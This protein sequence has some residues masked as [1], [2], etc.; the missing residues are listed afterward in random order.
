MGTWFQSLVEQIMMLETFTKYLHDHPTV[1]MFSA[2]AGYLAT[3]F[4]GQD[5]LITTLKFITIILGT[6]I[7]AITLYLKL[8]S[9]VEFRREKKKQKQLQ[10]EKDKQGT[11]GVE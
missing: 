3:L 8:Q 2:F 11:K 5:V 10:N 7:A 6:C 1:G 9:L 4:P